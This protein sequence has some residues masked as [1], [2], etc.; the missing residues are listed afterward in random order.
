[1]NFTQSESYKVNRGWGL[2][3]SSGIADRERLENRVK[4]R[5]VSRIGRH[6]HVNHHP[7]WHILLGTPPPG[8]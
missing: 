6:N 4:L 2:I 3:R 7:N 8:T 5:I 1:M